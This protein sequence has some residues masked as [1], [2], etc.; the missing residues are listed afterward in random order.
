MSKVFEI[1]TG[2]ELPR[3]ETVDRLVRL[4]TEHFSYAHQW[5]EGDCLVRLGHQHYNKLL[6]YIDGSLCVSVSVSLPLSLPLSLSLSLS[7]SLP[8]SLPC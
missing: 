8:P 7:L 3:D 5:Q 4:T 6:V 1:S 2:K